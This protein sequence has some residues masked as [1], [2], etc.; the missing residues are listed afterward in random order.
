MPT[1]LELLGINAPATYRGVD[2]LPIHGTSMAYSLKAPDAP[3]RK[4]TQYYEML[5]DR[6]IWHQGW[7]AVSRHERGANFEDDRWELYHLDADFSECHDLANQHPEKLRELI[8]RWWAEAGRYDVLPLDDRDA[9]RLRATL[10]ARARRRYVYYPD[11]A[12]IDRVNA[13]DTTDRTH[14]ISAELEVPSESAEGVLLSAGS[15]FGG[16]VLFVQDGRPAFEYV[17]ADGTS[18]LIRSDRPLPTGRRCTVRYDFTRTGEH[19]GR[20]ALSIDGGV[21]GTGDLPKTWRLTGVA[22]SVTCGRDGG[23]PTSDAYV[24][25]FSFT[26]T[27]HRVV[28]ELDGDGAAGAEAAYRTSLAEE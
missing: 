15:R 18:Y 16:Y 28:V 25:P 5:G 21:V 27:L 12:R 19:Q 9:D 1:V 23:C 11:M 7:K 26:G 10:A 6:A 24:A 20:G 13:P 3:T 14:S 4:E 17:Y 2:Q 22:G 8:E